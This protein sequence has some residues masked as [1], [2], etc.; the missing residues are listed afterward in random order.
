MRGLISPILF[1]LSLFSLK[2]IAC[3]NYLPPMTNIDFDQSVPEAIKPTIQTYTNNLNE[4]LG[5][6]AITKTLNVT[7][8]EGEASSA[9]AQ[10]QFNLLG[11]STVG[12]LKRAIF[13]HEFGHLVFWNHFVV[14]ILNKKATMAEHFE[15]MH[16]DI[17]IPRLLESIKDLFGPYDELFADL[18]AALEIK[19]GKAV[20]NEIPKE[21][22]KR[23]QNK[24]GGPVRDF[25]NV[26]SFKGWQHENFIA[27]LYSMLDP[28]RGALWKKY[29]KAKMTPSEIQK[30]L[31][32]F[33]AAA[34]EH[35]EMRLARGETAIDKKDATTL[36]K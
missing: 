28:V 11:L 30:L 12:A 26:I 1:A 31:K 21:Y 27:N 25:E 4:M 3:K 33:L 16:E 22:R 35:M 18:V 19:D 29:F 7:M 15:S 2:A 32:A 6:L 13:N 20:F 9:G 17:K 10:P 24:N 5:E 23:E 14:N 34:S 8:F 36:N